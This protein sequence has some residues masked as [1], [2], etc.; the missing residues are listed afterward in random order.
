M[1]NINLFS[2]IITVLLFVAVS[3]VS[4]SKETV[5]DNKKVEFEMSRQDVVI[6][7]MKKSVD[8]FS[9]QIKTKGGIDN[10]SILENY[11]RNLDVINK[12]TGLA[13]DY[14]EEEIKLVVKDLN[15]D[16]VERGFYTTYEQNKIYIDKIKAEGN[17]KLFVEV[18]SILN[19]VNG[20]SDESIDID[21]DIQSLSW[22]CGW[23][24]A[25]NFV[26]TLSLTACATGVGCPLAIAGKVIAMAGVASSCM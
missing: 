2:I 25:G 22:G 24:L 9:N 6:Y 7:G 12:H 19:D 16:F 3:V 15:G 20:W 1:K 11:R 21:D 8:I 17:Y 13:L 10:N 18:C 14:D 4:C 5:I 23:A 26:A